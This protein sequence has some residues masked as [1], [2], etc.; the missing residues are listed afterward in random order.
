M[1]LGAARAVPASTVGNAVSGLRQAPLQP[2][3]LRSKLLT[4]TLDGA[5][6]LPYQY[7]YGGETI[8]GEDMGMPITAILCRLEPRSYKTVPLKVLSVEG[9]PREAVFTFAVPWEGQAGAQFGI[10]YAIDEASLVITL[11]S[12]MEH[13]GFELIEVALPNLATVREGDR[14]AWMA[15]GRNG[16]SFVRVADAKPYRYEDDGYFGRISTELP[17]GAVGAGGIGCVLEVTAFMDATETLI[18]AV[19][20]MRSARIG[21]IQ[22]HRVHGGRCYNMNDGKDAVCGNGQTPNLLVEQ[23]SRCR[24]DFY[25]V[26]DPAVPWFPAAKLLRSR[27]PQR[28]TDYFDDKLLYM[29]A[30]KLKTEPEPRT[31]F[32]QSRMLVDEIARLTDYAPQVAYISGWVY[33][34]Q[35]TGYPSEDVVNASLG[36]YDEL[37]KLMEDSRPLHANVS[38]N[39]NYDDAYKSSPLFD[40]AFIAREPNGALWKSRAWDGEDSYIVGM[41]KYVLGGWARRRIDAMMARYRLRNALLIDAMSWFTI[42]NDWDVKHPAS[43]YKNLV[44]GKWIVIEEFRKRGVY[45]TSEQFRY[46]MAGKLALTVN[47][48]E[49]T[50]CPFGGQQV[51]LTAIVYRQATIFGGSGDGKLRPRES[52]FWNSRPGLWFENKT[53]RKE[54]ADFYFL[55]VLPFN[56]V[57]ALDV[58]SYSTR[59]AVREIRME[60]DSSIWMDAAGSSYGVKWNGLTITA[61]ESTT[62]P[63]DSQRIAFYSK[64]GARLS[65]PLPAQWK[66]AE[67]TARRLT[68]N[69]R[70]PFPVRIEGGQIVV[71]VPAQAPV[72]VYARESAVAAPKANQS[73]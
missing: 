63:V 61:N 37:M 30:G 21:T 35:D 18:A 45:V 67:V 28:P 20:G 46:P 3:L 53:D 39:V 55:V 15:Q 32:A 40:P 56:K 25:K 31:T 73:A 70:E 26:E 64:A 51:P 16:G 71:E 43:G 9:H 12:V 24:L 8:W 49:P 42:R 58:E 57:H 4:V 17:M 7:E 13:P 59:G 10:R 41:A 54:I 65:Y 29:I 14:A 48:P 60:G 11:E 22:V 50:N 38:V 62:C 23:Q 27:M 33:A 36:S 6:G 19:K 47:G 68:I 52:L 44:D 69:G 5:D 66:A 2:L 1:A 72:M 34:G